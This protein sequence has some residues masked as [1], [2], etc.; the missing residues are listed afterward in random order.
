M[1]KILFRRNIQMWSYENSF[2]T[3]ENSYESYENPH[4]TYANSYDTHENSYETYENSCEIYEWER[5]IPQ[6]NVL[7]FLTN[8]NSIVR[9]H[10]REFNDV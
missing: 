10:D 5:E 6:M 2:E 9:F 1:D 3:H 8:Q 7:L 4:K